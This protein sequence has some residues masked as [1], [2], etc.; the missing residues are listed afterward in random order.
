MLGHGR[1]R[2]RKLFHD[3]SADAAVLSRQQPEDL[4]SGRMA[5][6]FGH[7]RQLFIGGLSFDR[8]KVG[9]GVV[10]DWRAR[11]I[12]RL[13]TIYHSKPIGQDAPREGGGTLVKNLPSGSRI[14]WRFHGQSAPKIRSEAIRL[15]M[16]AFDQAQIVMPEPTYKVRP[17][18]HVPLAKKSL[19]RR[20]RT[21]NGVSDNRRVP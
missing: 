19:G 17:E 7:S 16:E 14:A 18:Q 15:V 2:Q 5:E 20:G 4:N 13:F 8:A 21:R 12:H 1:L 6:G 3:V 10:G 11:S 9:R